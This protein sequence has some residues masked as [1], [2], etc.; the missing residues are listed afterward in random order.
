[1]HI[2]GGGCDFDDGRSFLANLS[3][4]LADGV[5]PR[6]PAVVARAKQPAAASGEAAG[7]QRR[8]RRGSLQL[9]GR[10]AS[11]LRANTLQRLVGRGR[12]AGSAVPSMEDL[13]AQLSRSLPNLI[14]ASFNPDGS[15]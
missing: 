14:S 13:Q 7:A 4:G 2:E 15:E 8:G 12:T 10:V 11:L 6:E 5:V 3:A 1:M 9:A